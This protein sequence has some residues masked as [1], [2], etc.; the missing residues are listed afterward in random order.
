MLHFYY[1]AYI[2]SKKKIIELKEL[3][4]GE[5]KNL[6]KIIT[7]NNNSLIEK[8]FNNLIQH[9]TG[10]DPAQ[11]T[12]LDKLIILL[13]VRSVCVLS[14][15]ELLV[16]SPEDSQTYNVSYRI[17]DIIERLTNL[18][19][20]N[21]EHITK[22]Y[23]NTLE[24][25]FGLPSALFIDNTN[26]SLSAVIKNIRVEDTDIPIDSDDI[27]DHIP[28]CVFK[29]AKDFLKTIESKINNINLMSINT[30][31]TSQNNALEVPLTLVENSVLEFLKLCYKKDLI[32]IYELEYILTSKMNLSHTLV[33]N[34]TPAELM[35]Y[36]NFFNKEKS[37]SDKQ[38]KKS[39]MIGPPPL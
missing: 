36:I 13:T 14:D 26:K 35:L 19:L 20:E 31:G 29:D 8:A 37:E 33:Y 1:T 4:F 11:F 23:N 25:T 7:N 34:S 9:V 2:P 21:S 6:V 38:Q 15:I 5:Y 12:F 16:T 28:L 30:P 24:I 3:H 10:C 27:Y 32:S 17:Y 18:D 39:I 22:L